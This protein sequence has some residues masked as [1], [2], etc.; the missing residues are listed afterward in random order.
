[1]GILKRRSFLLDLFCRESQQ[2]S[3]SHITKVACVARKIK[4][5]SLKWFPCRINA[6]LDFCQMPWCIY[7]ADAR[8]FRTYLERVQN[9]KTKHLCL[10]QYNDHTCVFF[11]CLLGVFIVYPERP[12]QILL[13]FLNLFMKHS[14]NFTRSDLTSGFKICVFQHKMFWQIPNSLAL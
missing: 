12:R 14:F 6:F 2:V 1:M 8:E 10:W 3:D 9:F 13:L 11:F 5:R 4:P 7:A